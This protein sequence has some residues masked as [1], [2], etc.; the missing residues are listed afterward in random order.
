MK[1]ALF[2]LSMFL[3]AACEMEMEPAKQY[4]TMEDL[5]ETM[6]AQGLRH[7]R[8]EKNPHLT[9]RLSTP[10]YDIYLGKEQFI[11]VEGPRERGGDAYT[12]YFRAYE[13]R[14]WEFQVRQNMLMIARPA[15]SDSVVRA[16]H[17]M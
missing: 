15:A 8:V 9:D 13:A 6:R 11:V 12:G 5:V 14:G 1:K 7:V 3:L 2:V 10:T 16:L 17:G 4:Y